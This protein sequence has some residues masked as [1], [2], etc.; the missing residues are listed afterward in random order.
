VRHGNRWLMRA[1]GEAA[2]AA[3]RTKGSYFAAQFHRIAA[4]RGKNRALMAVAHSLLTV[5][6]HVL[7]NH[8]EYQELGANYF[9]RLTPERLQRTLIKRLE[10]LGFEVTIRPNTDQNN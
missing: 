4:R 3:S 5:I 8:E 1:L 2:W 10:G 6:Y 7:K 9:D